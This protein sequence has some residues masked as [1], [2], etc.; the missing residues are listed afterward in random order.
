MVGPADLAVSS[1]LAPG[2]PE[3]ESLTEAAEKSCA[4]AGH[5]LGT[6]APDGPGAARRFARGYRFVVVATETA[7]LA[8]ATREMTATARPTGPGNH[9]APARD[10]Q[11]YQR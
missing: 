1:G 8:R 4:Q 3:L 2:A 7:L 5:P 9:P 10:H 11:E 6:T